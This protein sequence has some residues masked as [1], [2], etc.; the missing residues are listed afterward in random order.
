M[1]TIG[2]E[3]PERIAIA[4]STD[5]RSS[6]A[7]NATALTLAKFAARICTFAL[8]IVMGRG[9]GVSDYGRYGFAGA[10]GVIVLAVAD[11]GITP[12]VVREVARDRFTGDERA[13][14]LVRFKASLSLSALGAVIVTAMALSGA[15]GAATVIILVIAS[16]LAD[17]VTGFVYGYFQG[18]E[19]MGFE[20]RSTA[21]AALV[22]S[23]GGIACVFAFGSLLTVLA[24]MLLVSSAQ[25]AVALVRFTGTVRRPARGPAEVSKAAISWRSVTAMGGIAFFAL[26]YLQADSVIVGVVYDH[27]AVGLYTAAYALVAGL[28]ILPW[29]IAVAMAPVFARSHATDRAGFRDAWQDGLRIV[30]VLSLPL[31]LVTSIL[32]GEIMRLLFGESFRSAAPALAVLVWSSPVWAVNMTIAGVL[33]GAGRERW[34]VVTTGVGAVVNLGLNFWAIPAFGIDG[35]AAVTVATELSVL[36]IQGWLIVSRDVAPFPRLPYGRL[37]LALL[38]L[39]A[40]AVGSRGLEVVAAAAAALVAYAVVV[41]ATGAV[42]P[43]EL[44]A[45]RSLGFR[46]R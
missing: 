27:R 19:R 13:V 30:L 43:A 22:R 15:T 46:P 4:P 16:M 45:L 17:G 7:R 18:R 11:I 36:L 35:A 20:A 28:Q 5:E 25:V 24:W 29:Q 37:G 26:V 6:V 31:A 10:V 23:V 32:A 39:A 3:A 40:V 8:A 34:L 38:A 1:D 12:Y 33:R 9:L 41:V 44:Q 14:R 42:R 2:T 21:V